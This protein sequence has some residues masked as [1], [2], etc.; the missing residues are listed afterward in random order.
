MHWLKPVG[1]QAAS[2]GS[3]SLTVTSNIDTEQSRRGGKERVEQDSV[4]KCVGG[5]SGSLLEEGRG[6]KMEDPRSWDNRNG[7]K[8]ANL[9]K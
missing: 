9:I 1:R 6:I 2:E 4:G 8:V 3:L 7:Y 5:G